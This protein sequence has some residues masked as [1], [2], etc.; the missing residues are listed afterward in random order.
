VHVDQFD[1]EVWM[2]EHEM[3]ATWNL[4]ETCIDSLTLDELLELGGHAE[5]TLRELLGRKLTY[6]DITGAPRLRQLIAALYESIDPECVLLTHGAIG[7]NFLAEYTL[8]EP[9]DRVVCVQPTYQQL[10]SV[11]ASFGADVRLLRLRPEDGFLP[12]IDEL[13]DLAGARAK[14]ICINN[15]NNPTGALIPRGLLEQIV[16]VARH[17]G[18]YLLADEVYRGLEH[19]RG[20]VTPSVSDLYERGV[21]TGS[22]SKVFSLAGLR[23]G[24]VVAAPEVIADCQRHRDYTTI[25]CSMLDEALAGEAIEHKDRLLERNLRLMLDNAAMLRDWIAGEP[26]ISWVPPAAGTTAFL[27]Y[28]YDLASERFAQELFDFN[29][30]FLV[31]GSCF[32]TDGWLRVGY[33]CSPV[34]LRGGL[35]GISACLRQLEMRGL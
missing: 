22:M 1:V 35:D 21:S 30:T 11:P 17:C 8:V 13:R 31:P 25:S 34:V 29:G 20:V 28:D 24:W 3:Q 6:G 4:G 15:P 32:A 9:G 14:L 7:A 26:R 10:Y 23:L 18:A 33:A 19:D 2:N 27:R 12:D 16:E 5:A